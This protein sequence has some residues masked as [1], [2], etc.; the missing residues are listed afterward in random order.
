MATVEQQCQEYFEMWKF[1]HPNIPVYSLE[2][3]S[4]Q[5]TKDILK[6][7]EERHK[8]LYNPLIRGAMI[9]DLNG[10]RQQLSNFK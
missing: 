1:L 7:H 6:L 3:N 2:S 9:A 10:V 8:A 5:G 4:L